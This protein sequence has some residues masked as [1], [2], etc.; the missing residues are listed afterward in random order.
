MNKRIKDLNELQNYIISR[1]KSEQIK[2]EIHE[3]ESGAAM[4]DIWKD[5]LFYVIQLERELI[6]L[7]LIK[8]NTVFDTIPDKTYKDKTDFLKDFELCIQGVWSIGHRS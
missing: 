8:D 6:G 4:V 3:F 2:F 1:L 5:N 7:S